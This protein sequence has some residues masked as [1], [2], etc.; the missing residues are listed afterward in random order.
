MIHSM[1]LR[2]RALKMFLVRADRKN[3]CLRLYQ[4]QDDENG[5]W[6]ESARKSAPS[7]DLR[8]LNLCFTFDESNWSRRFGILTTATLTKPIG[9]TIEGIFIAAGYDQKNKKNNRRRHRRR[10]RPHHRHRHRCRQHIPFKN[11]QASVTQH[12]T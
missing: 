1:P 4:E 9:H 8:R 10:P 11:L 12:I 2:V 5:R 6:S 3:L 7:I